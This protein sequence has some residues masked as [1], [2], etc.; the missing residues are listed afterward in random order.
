MLC[1]ILL[2]DIRIKGNYACDPFSC[3]TTFYPYPH[4]IKRIWVYSKV[5]HN[6]VVRKKSI[7]SFPQ[8]LVMVLERVVHSSD[9]D[10]KRG[11]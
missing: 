6:K 2:H 7:R 9:A 11:I 3:Y 5:R 8:Y 4:Q 10:I 1:T